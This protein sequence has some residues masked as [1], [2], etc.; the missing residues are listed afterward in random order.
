MS[1]LDII[2][3]A[4][5]RD[6]ASSPPA[7]PNDGLGFGSSNST[8][9]VIPR[10]SAPVA[11]TPAMSV[12]T[13][14]D[15]APKPIMSKAPPKPT[16]KKDGIIKSLAKSVIPDTIKNV[17]QGL[18]SPSPLTQLASGA[19]AA[20]NLP[21][22]LIVRPL[23][24]AVLGT[25]QDEDL[26]AGISAK[27]PAS[28]PFL[29][30]G[31]AAYGRV[32]PI[33]AKKVEQL[34]GAKNVL[35]QDPVKTISQEYTEGRQLGE[36][37]VSSQLPEDT[38]PLIRQ[39]ATKAGGGSGGLLFAGLLASDLA[40]GVGGGKKV[41]KGLVKEGGEELLEQGSKRLLKEAPDKFLSKFLAGAKPRYKDIVPEFASE[42]DKAAYIVAKR[43][44]P[45]KR[46][47]E[48]LSELMSH[49][50]W[51]KEQ[52]IKHGEEVRGAVKTLASKAKQGEGLVVPVQMSK[53]VPASPVASA[54]AESLMSKVAKGGK[55]DVPTN[56]SQ[57]IPKVAPSDVDSSLAKVSQEVVEPP[58]MSKVDLPD[59]PETTK[60]KQLFRTDKVTEVPEE[61]KIIEARREAL[62]LTTRDVRTH[63][64]V[65]KLAYESGIDI[66]TLLDNSTKAGLTD[67]QVVQLRSLMKPDTSEIARLTALKN[68]NPDQELS[69]GMEIA[70]HE[71]QLD[72]TLRKFTAGQTETA[73]ALSAMRLTAMENMDQAYWLKR[74]QR[75]A[76]RDLTGSEVHNIL[77][78]AGK[79]DP[80]KIV[81]AVNAVR[82]ESD[83]LD[84]T[85]GI[86][87][88]G[89]L[90]SPT[91][92]LANMGGNVI[93]QMMETA[94]DIPAAM[95]DTVVSAI[96]GKPR[97]VGFNLEGSLA[98]LHVG[99]AWKGL[100][101]GGARKAA[102]EWMDG[103]RRGIAEEE[104]LKFDLPQ[105]LTFDQNTFFGKA[106]QKYTDTVFG[107]LSMQDRI[108]AD[109]AMK[110]SLLEQAKLAAKEVGKKGDEFTAEV[111][112][113]VNKPTEDML[114]NAINDSEY[115]TFHRNTTIGNML[116]GLQKGANKT[117]VGKVAAEAI[118][119]F[120]KTPAAVATTILDYTPAGFI[121]AVAKGIKGGSQR[122]VIQS[123]SRA[124]TGT[125]MI[126]SG[127]ILAKN[128]LITGSYPR[129]PKER[130]IWQQQKAIPNA[131][132]IDGHWI[133]LSRL[134]PFG[135]ILGIGA[136]S[137]NTLQD[138]GDLLDVAKSGASSAITSFGDQP[139]VQGMSAVADTL[140][141]PERNLMTI[142]KQLAGSIVPALL[143]RTAKVIDPIERENKTIKDAFLN[144]VPGVSQ[145]QDE[146]LDAFGRE[147]K[148]N[149]PWYER[150]VQQYF[151]P[152]RV[153][154]IDE[155]PVFKKMQELY[156]ANEPIM[157]TAIQDT[158]K[159]GGFEIPMEK[160]EKMNLQRAIGGVQLDEMQKAIA[161]PEFQTL[162]LEQQS[163]ALQGMMNDIYNTVRAEMFA[164]QIA[165]NVLAL[166]KAIASGDTTAGKK[167]LAFRKSGLLKNPTVQF[168]LQRL[169]QSLL[170][171]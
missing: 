54:P 67:D 108:F 155:N 12:A 53:A 144:R 104:V 36:N 119:P 169:G 69:I 31:A 97:T 122:E 25:M 42:I 51:T 48:Y 148:D 112:K 89:L 100:K 2:K 103:M 139:Y 73:R 77:D 18:A 86:W 87:K 114:Q 164:P 39:L 136:D 129:D 61:V 30:Q 17:K 120:K 118:L 130:I 19:K 82:R 138:G 109:N 94:K 93:M 24:R 65:K 140:K 141:D 45:S 11:Q 28:M 83:I 117:A 161:D 166:Q 47:A 14:A 49:T 99:D 123:L 85:I 78:A 57:E 102:S 167:L 5:S 32:A 79:K 111:K 92:H 27:A 157:P 52:A 121:T 68:A 135:A 40:P 41:V 44:T 81:E 37:V 151:S 15:K 134:G 72:K 58:P 124:L 60:V 55:K 50:G 20:V 159:T 127:A 168:E 137:Y 150:A 80:L 33:I 71:S 88:A 154:V 149:R 59:D 66:K 22:E 95:I 7:Q 91:T 101:E 84:K 23:A 170:A 107:A 162:P 143:G 145:S 142:P 74:A 26:I 70:K 147:L 146:K 133:E 38:N 4:V 64:E 116:S 13:L 34:P 160:K 152:V 110:R 132:K 98:G 113:L 171:E 1:V 90:S 165:Q 153:N 46:D 125:A 3:K 76:G 21:K 56:L 128:N 106:A 35:G 158:L 75:E 63:E 8:T 115:A 156:D 9:A 43:G 10:S 96:R 6:R 163:K 105:K 126:G 131:V 16:A 29:K 62:G